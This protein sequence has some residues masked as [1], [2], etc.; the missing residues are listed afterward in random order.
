MSSRQPNYVKYWY[1]AE[2]GLTGNRSPYSREK[3]RQMM[4]LFGDGHESELICNYSAKI[5]MNITTIQVIIQAPRM[6]KTNCLKPNS[7]NELQLTQELNR[8]NLTIN[9]N[10]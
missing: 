2:S 3:A 8:L 9:W 6:Q 7:T 1:L 10:R 5:I 4:M